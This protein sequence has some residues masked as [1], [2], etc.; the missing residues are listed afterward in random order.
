MSSGG[1]TRRVLVARAAAG[2][3]ALAAPGVA[4]AAAPFD[5]VTT[6][7]AAL[8]SAPAPRPVFY[9]RSDRFRPPDIVLLSPKANAPTRPVFRLRIGF[10]AYQGASIETS[11][12]RVAYWKSPAVDLTQR[13]AQFFSMGGIFIPSAR[14]PSGSHTLRVSVADSTHNQQD[15]TFI[16]VVL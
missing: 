16:I 14:F 12:I 6:A 4:L 3:G 7:E 13:L 5:V 8:P 9:E 15:A 11:S 2:A 10:K 1:Q